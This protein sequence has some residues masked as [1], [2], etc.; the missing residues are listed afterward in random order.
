MET[1]LA[2]LGYD[3]RSSCQANQRRDWVRAATLT[4]QR[5]KIVLLN[6]SRGPLA[7]LRDTD[8]LTF[9]PEVNV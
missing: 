7:N 1:T 8:R 4:I 9:A 5:L 2:V 6:H 3:R